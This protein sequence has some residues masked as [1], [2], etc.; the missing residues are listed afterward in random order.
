MR[1]LVVDH[2]YPPAVEAIYGAD[3]E[4][5]ELPYAAQLERVH[6]ALFGETAFEVAALAETG[7]DASDWLLNVRPLVSAWYQ[8]A[9][10]VLPGSKIRP[11]LRRG[12]LPWMGRTETGW[13]SEALLARVRELQPDVVHIQCP[14]LVPTDTLRALRPIARLVSGQLASDVPPDIDFSVYGLM[15]SSVPSLVRRFRASGINAE[16][17]PLAFEASLPDRIGPLARDVAVSFVGSISASHSS[18]VDVLDAVAKAAHLEVWTSDSSAIPSR[19]PIRPGLHVAAFGR[20]MYSI[21]R[22]SRIALNN[23]ARIAEGEANNLRLYEA[24]G[25]GA[26]LVTEAAP[27]LRDL[28]DVDREVVT[29]RNPA[30]AAAVVR[31]YVEH[32]DE[33]SVIAAAGQSRTL[34]DHNWRNRM[35]R[36]VELAASRI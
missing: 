34:H 23:H 12:W 3:R 33:A 35:S 22:R 7:H 29:Y 1:L 16:W 13:T 9:G 15:V 36:L 21:L 11:R 31:H 27:N 8:E 25:M 26:L 5:A 17:L 4:L 30:D 10:R 24:T 2:Y 14:S 20:G 18:R 28:F 6:D 32:P 19:S